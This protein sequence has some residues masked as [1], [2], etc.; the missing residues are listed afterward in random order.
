MSRV[1]PLRLAG[2]LV[3]AVL[4][5]ATP[6]AAVVGGQPSE[7]GRWPFV[8]AIVTY[9]AQPASSGF[10][11]TGTHVSPGWVLTAAHCVTGSAASRPVDPAS[12]EVVLGSDALDDEGERLRVITTIVHPDYASDTRRNDLALLELDRVPEV[13]PVELAA[14]P[15]DTGTETLAVGW[16]RTEPD[17]PGPASV[18]HEAVLTTVADAECEAAYGSA[19]NPARQVCALGEQP[20]EG[21]TPDTCEGDSGGPLLQVEETVQ[22]VAVTSYGHTPCGNGAPGVYGRVAA[23]RTWILDVIAQS[24]QGGSGPFL[25][26]APADGDTSGVATALAVS[27]HRFTTGETD[28][29]VL[30]TG[31]AF[32]DALAGSSLAYGAAPLLFTAAERLEPAVLEELRRVVR[33]GGTVFVLGGARAVSDEVA[34]EVAAS[35]FAVQR[36]AGASREATA[37]VVASQVH[38]ATGGLARETVIVATAHAWPDAVLAGQLGAWWG[39]PVL[40]TPPDG[41]HPETSAAIR[42]LG[43]R[44]V[45]VVGGQAAIHESTLAA[46]GQLAGE[47]MRLGGS[48]RTSTG[49]AV[50]RHHAALLEATGDRPPDA[51]YAINVRRDEAYAHVLAAT[52]LVGTTAGVFAP[53]EGQEGTVLTSEVR[54]WLCGLGGEFAAVG[55]VAAVSDGAAQAVADLLV[56]DCAG[57]GA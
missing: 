55:A 18:L 25:R 3:I 46:L 24:A 28:M 20:D 10:R 35:G 50:A 27:R 57:H 49:V 6:G 2:I 19:V 23:Y 16:G 5:L 26:I 42:E 43:A 48:S 39:F 44:R 33:P 40:L 45:L 21:P 32:P 4:T 22:Q 17:T 12:L 30:A 53:V 31:R 56:G 34:S 47:A 38:A 11:C 37:R 9:G 1:L 36:L 13:P 54:E 15:L 41:V 29:T 7:P 14:E 52:M 8:A 51:V